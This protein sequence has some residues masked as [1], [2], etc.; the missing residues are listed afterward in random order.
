MVRLRRHGVV[1]FVALWL[2][3]CAYYGGKYHRAIDSSEIIRLSPQKTRKLVKAGQAYLVCAYGDEATFR[4][5]ALEG[6]LSLRAF[7]KRHPKFPSDRLVIFFGLGAG[8]EKA[9]AQAARHYNRGQKNVAVLEGGVAGW[10][11][12]GFKIRDPITL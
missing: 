5:I 10:K 9:A 3:G 1:L 12:V 6:A 11:F 8:E 4:K 7:R 2:A